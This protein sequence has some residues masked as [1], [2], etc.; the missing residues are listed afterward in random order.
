MKQKYYLSAQVL[1]VSVFS[2]GQI[3]IN[4][5]DPT[6]TLDVNGE[7]R[8]RTLPSGNVIDEVLVA[9]TNG[10][11]RKIPRNSFEGEGAYSKGGFNSTILGYEPQPVAN[12]VV[13]PTAPGGASVTEL[14]C[15]QY[16]QNGH[17][18]CVYDLSTGINW[19]NAFNFAKNLGGYLVTLTSHAETDWVYSEILSG[20]NLSNNIWIG[21]NKITEPGNTNRF[22]WITGEEFRINWGTNPATAEHR[23]DAGEP[24]NYNGNEGSTHIIG[25]GGSC[26]RSWNDT[27]GNNTSAA[28]GCTTGSITA[29]NKIINKLIIEFNE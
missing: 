10:N 13:P 20:Y 25:A 26:A 9:D 17:H 23:F 19:Y 27:D 11:I 16:S 3:G 1:A 8:V 28:A 5:N 15:K 21:Y 29:A 2:F 14:G 22:R 18:Y 24:N 7:V 4:T 6:K 12:K